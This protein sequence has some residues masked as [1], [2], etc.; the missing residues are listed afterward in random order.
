M[1]ALYG[2]ACA[3]DCCDIN[4]LRLLAAQLQCVCTVCGVSHRCPP[5]AGRL[6]LRGAASQRAVSVD[7]GRLE[8]M[9]ASTGTLL[10]F[11]T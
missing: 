10:Q 5:A 9:P 6:A 7:A 2:L 3:L 8:C 4:R 1:H 11:S